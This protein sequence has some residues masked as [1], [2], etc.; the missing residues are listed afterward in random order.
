[1]SRFEGLF[2]SRDTE[3]GD[4]KD[5]F[6]TDN[7]TSQASSSPFMNQYL[8]MV[9]CPDAPQPATQARNSNLTTEAPPTAP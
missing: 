3:R 6:C 4:H 9:A 1:M 5:P 8:P 2:D 7:D